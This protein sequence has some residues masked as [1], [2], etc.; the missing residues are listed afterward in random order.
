MLHEKPGSN[1]KIPIVR[2]ACNVSVKCTFSNFFMLAMSTKVGLE[3]GD[4]V[5]SLDLLFEYLSLPDV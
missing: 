3:I 5:H 2:D 1:G 4:L